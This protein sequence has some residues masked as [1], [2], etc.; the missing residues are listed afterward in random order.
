MSHP[1]L[2][3][4]LGL[5]ES[6]SD[7]ALLGI[8][9]DT[10]LTSEQITAVLAERLASLDR[11]PGAHSPAAAIVRRRLGEAA[12]R[13][14]AGSVVVPAH[15]TPKPPPSFA[16]KEETEESPDVRQEDPPPPPR[17]VAAPRSQ[18]KKDSGHRPIRPGEGS[19]AGL[20]DFDRMVLAILVGSGGWN[21]AS[22]SRLIGLASRRGLNPKGLL[23][24]VSG[25]A[26]LLHGGGFE[27]IAGTKRAINVAAP[28]RYDLPQ[29]SR[30]ESTMNQIS[31]A[32][33]TE[34]RAETSGA[35]MRVAI[36]FS[37][38]TIMLIALF[39][40]ALSL[41]SPAIQRA[42]KQDARDAALAEVRAAAA[43]SEPSEPETL[44]YPGMEAFGGAIDDPTRAIELVPQKIWSVS[45]NFRAD[46]RPRAEI[47]RAHDVSDWIALLQV[48]TRK[49]SLPQAGDN[50]A[51]RREYGSFVDDAGR[52]W[53][54]LDPAL[55]AQL[56]T[57]LVEPVGVAAS[58][59]LRTDLVMILAERLDEIDHPLDIWR[60]SWS[61]GVLGSIAS[62]VRQP[63]GARAAASEIL[64]L[65][66]GPRR[67]TRAPSDQPFESTVGRKL[68]AVAPE[69]V[70]IAEQNPEQAYA[71]WEYWI[72]AQ[73][74]IRRGTSLDAALL[75]AIDVILRESDALERSGPMVNILGR[76]VSELEFSARAND[77][78]LM[79]AN[80]RAWLKDETIPSDH[81]WVLSS[82]LAQSV[83]VPWWDAS[84]VVSPGATM[85]VRGWYADL[86]DASWPRLS[87]SDR[88]RGI[89]VP[90]QQL[91]RL[92]VI[93]EALDVMPRPESDAA[94]M[95]RLLT[96]AHVTA[97]AEAL[98]SGD[99]DGSLEE[100]SLAE[101][102]L[103]EPLVL[104][105][106]PA[107]LTDSIGRSTGHDG[108]W[109]EEWIR[110][111]RDPTDRQAA[112]RYLKQRTDG[113]LGPVDSATLASEAFR[114]VPRELRLLA[115][116][117]IIEKFSLGPNMA[118]ALLDIFEFAPRNQ[119]TAGFI[120]RLTGA[121]L[122][123][124]SSDHWRESA[125]LALVR[126]A[127]FLLES[128][129][130]DVDRLAANYRSVLHA[131]LDRLGGDPY[132][133]RRN[134][135]ELAAAITDLVNDRAEDQYVSDP[136]PATLTELDRRRSVRWA[137]ANGEPQQLA[138]ELSAL[139]DLAT[140]Q[141][142][143][144]RPDL[145]RLI[146]ERHSDLT[147]RVAVA[148]D[149]LEQVFLLERAI[150]EMILMRLEA[151]GESSS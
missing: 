40:I 56:V 45:P 142:A 81:V 43:L 93:V 13:L 78:E 80:V 35:R 77:P 123:A 28:L 29:P 68:D 105:A 109:T 55:R 37:I 129:M 95:Y 134:A 96:W 107:E 144:L 119:D 136:I 26:Q 15:A 41:P 118:F 124:L 101:A 5:E 17:R 99:T 3:R 131:R 103:H 50:I 52:C 2:L 89:P 88:P 20:T 38:S 92:N 97:A 70:A 100:I 151:D 62:G 66:L 114:G 90:A 125:R 33:A 57:A 1:P 27:T 79:Q 139:G 14:I 64:M 58:P 73:R 133:L 138:A 49:A 10:P 23:R 42:R 18:E 141:T 46:A 67:R 91:D 76:L 39:A 12:G 21:A 87:E 24:I 115:Q 4:F 128:E 86:V 59:R 126:H 34:F 108:V 69:L 132:A 135:G 113:D 83:D 94:A 48:I 54:L 32:L 121:S 122:P 104:L 82:M 51:L 145:R 111:R 36:Y 146:S 148:P 30:L 98:E 6:A 127:T 65:D 9:E 130:H 150:A 140:Y 16:G 137:S 149:V 120:G 74:T 63:E 7:R 143:G 8:D 116:E 19:I 85:E 75:D 102:M 71:F 31:A 22:R 72:E 25:L 11:H 53:P 60:S 117:T 110:M 44:I 147:S 112:L 106:H 84:F 47:L 61:S